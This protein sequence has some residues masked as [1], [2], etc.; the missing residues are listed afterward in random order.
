M[1]FN[2]KH[3]L[4]KQSREDTKQQV[5]HKTLLERISTKFLLS[6]CFETLLQ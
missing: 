1:I 3:L 4:S 2:V 6:L 5:I